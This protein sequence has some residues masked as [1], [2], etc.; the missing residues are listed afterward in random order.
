MPA[1]SPF[2]ETAEGRRSA[3]GLRVEAGLAVGGGMEMLALPTAPVVPTSAN[4]LFLLVTKALGAV[5]S[6]EWDGV[7]DHP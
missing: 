5:K 2:I 1:P 6:T 7:R 4:R 3:N